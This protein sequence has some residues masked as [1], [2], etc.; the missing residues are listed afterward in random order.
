MDDCIGTGCKRERLQQLLAARDAEI[1]HLRRRLMAVLDAPRE[2]MS[3]AKAVR[4]M[5]RQARLGLDESPGAEIEAAIANLRHEAM[6][7]LVAWD[8]TVLPKSHDG[9]MQERMECLRAAL[10][11][12][13]A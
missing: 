12:L 2:T 4:E 8:G 7:A 9:L 5:V 6:R 13:G 1:E 11:V 10:A 3:D